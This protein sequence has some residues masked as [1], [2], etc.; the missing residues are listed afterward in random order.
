MILATACDKD[1]EMLKVS[2]PGT[3]SELSVSP[4][5]VVLTKDGTDALALSIVW[6]AGSLPEASDPT[7][8]LPD[9]LTEQSIQFSAT[10]D[11]A[12][13]V[14]VSLSKDCT[15]VQY[16]GSE[17]LQLLVKL[18][19]TDAKQYDIYIRISM[20]MGGV[21]SYS[22]AVIVKVTPYAVDT[23]WMQIVDKNDVSSVL[24]TLHCKESSPY[25]YEGFAVPGSGWYNCFF[26]AADGTQ[27]GCD[28]DWTAFSLVS[29]STN[30]CWFAE[31]SGVQYVYAD[32]EN[33]M[34][35]H[36]HVPSISLDVAGVETELKYVKSKGGYSGTISTA[37]D[38][39]VITVSG[40]GSRFDITTGADAGVEGIA[41]PFS[42]VPVG[43]DSFEF[44][45]SGSVSEGFVIDKAGTYTITFSVSDCK[46]SVET[47]AAEPPVANYPAGVSMYYYQKEGSDRLGLACEMSETDTEGVFEG[48]VYTDPDWSEL[49]SNFRFLTDAGVVY[50]SNSDGQFVLGEDGWNCWSSN[51]GMNYILADF[52]T[53][54]WS[55][56]KVTQVA[57]SGDFNS[58]STES[59][60]MSFNMDTGKWEA[61]CDISTIEYGFKFVLGDAGNAW[62]WQ[63][64][65]TDMDGVLSLVGANDNIL[66]ASTGKFKIELDLSSFVSP[67]YSMTSIE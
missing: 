15:A 5:E 62:R 12:S 41:Y 33:G 31:P 35:W 36:V 59:D 34:W 7:V 47:G 52:T 30:N 8:A 57:V 19:L 16:T 50:S 27:W 54:T 48:F 51:T 13:Y 24:A 45:G 2:D 22:D 25:L 60:V 38:N 21:Y 29:N 55:E 10:E 65:D 14:E 46:W 49:F 18:G 4:S 9:N 37:S 23:G 3:P 26:I 32:T 40:S 28:A 58:W 67:S 42:L 1:G 44:V 43:S 66:P 11:F 63:Y 39:A 6:N 17:L 20:K 61:T 64:A 53:M 56:T